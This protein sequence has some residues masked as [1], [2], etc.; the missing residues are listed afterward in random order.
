MQ[1][2]QSWLQ[3]QLQDVKVSD[4]VCQLRVRMELDAPPLSALVRAECGL[5]NTNG[6]F[7]SSS[8]LLQPV[9]AAW[10]LN[11]SRPDSH[12]RRWRAVKFSKAG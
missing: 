11:A 9:L 5:A 4:K 12:D 8:A 1:N 6:S 2:L 10:Q 7:A 3:V